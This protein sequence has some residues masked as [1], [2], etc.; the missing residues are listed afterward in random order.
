MSR[1]LGVRAEIEILTWCFPK[2]SA[3]P[4]AQAVLL[5]TASDRVVYSTEGG[6]LLP[7]PP[8]TVQLCTSQGHS[9]QWETAEEAMGALLPGKGSER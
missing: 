6:F 5:S 9:A 1:Y 3:K 4:G 7:A 8:T 2:N